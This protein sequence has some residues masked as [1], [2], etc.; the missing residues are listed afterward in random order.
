MPPT[1]LA[2]N[3]LAYYGDRAQA[4]LDRHDAPGASEAEIRAAVRDFLIETKLATA[5]SIQ[6]EQSPGDGSSGRVDLRTRDVIFEF[7]VR[8][9]NRI[10]PEAKHVQQLDD[11]LSAALVGGQQQRFGILTDGKYWILRWPGMGSVNTQPPN[12][13]TLA[14]AD[15]GLLLYEWLRDQ[16]QA[17]EAPDIPPTEDEIRNR[18]GTGPRFDLHL[19]ALRDLYTEHR[20]HP[21]IAV[22]RELWRRLL[23]A[24]LGQVVEEDPDL[25]DLFLR[26]TYLSVVVGLA[27][28]SAFGIEIEHWAAG[29]AERLLNGQLFAD[30]TGLS[31]VVES[32]FFTWL[33]EVGGEQWLRDLARRIAQFDWP[34]ADSDIARI[35]YESVI[36]AEERRRLGE[37]YTPDW[38]ARAIVDAVVTDP[39]EQR[40][41][42]PACG[43]GAFIFAAV[44][45]Y[46]AAA[47][48]AGWVPAQALDG[49]LNHVVGIDVHPV[50]VHL[51]RA[52]WTFAARDA[53]EAA[54]DANM[55][56]TVPVYLGDS[57]QL[58]TES[59]GMFAQQTVTI[60]VPDPPDADLEFNRELEFPRA[61]VEQADRFDN[62]M[63]SMASTIES[64][65]DPVWAL[66]DKGI[67]EGDDRKM[68]ERTAKLLQ[69]LHEE[70]RDHIWAYYT[71]NLVRPVALRANPVD[72]IVGNPPWLTY[73]RSQAVVREELERQSKDRY[74]IW[75][76]GRNAPNQE[77]AGLFFARCAE[78]YLKPG[79]AAAMVL[80]HSALQAGPFKK[81]RSGQ[82]GVVSVDLGIQLPWDLERIQ[83][84]D[85]FPLPACVAFLKRKDP[86]G[87][88]LPQHADRWRGPLGGPFE[89]ESVPL[90][91]TSGGFAS[92]YGD[93]A[94]RGADIFPR[95]LYLV[96]LE[97]STALVRAANTLIVSP[98]RTSQ[99][100]SPWR[101]L[102]AAALDGQAIEAEHVFDVHLG[103]TVAPYVLL[104]PLKAVLPLSMMTG[105]LIKKED[106][107]YGLDPLSLGGRMRRRWKLINELWDEN[108][109]ENSKLELLANLDYMHKLSS[110]QS[111]N[112][113][114]GWLV[115]YGKAGRPTAAVMNA[116]GCLVDKT[117]IWVPC[118]KIEEAHFLTAIINSKVLQE[119]LEPLM[120]KG[121]FGARDIEKHLWRLPIPEYDKDISLHREI[122]E[123]GKSAAGG[124]AQ[125][126]S[127]VRAEREA[128][129]K[130]FTVTIARRELRR[131]LS[132]SDEGRT[133]EGLVG[134]L[135]G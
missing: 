124:A 45:K 6:M 90:M 110:Q 13:F 116:Q 128:S 84:N 14:S 115:V 2:A 82:W 8:I 99:E 109:G 20:D 113:K 39:L 54:R 102:E 56:V 66:D 76:G 77:M 62:L 78:L 71:R 11:Y 7:K 51:A 69:R 134:R 70:G 91:D 28:Q 86:P 1:N 34:N 53:I 79:G 114:T 92:P 103:T 126:L 130:G 104:E 106:G 41:L 21:T 9:G 107:W 35:L 101:E 65:G 52:T 63:T 44:R 18:L 25:D 23:A 27:V 12:A 42:D 67:D 4:I 118:Q 98:R 94:R 30:E 46:L 111:S 72:V 100:K 96:T 33:L 88:P 75:A 43:S 135:L 83:P 15:H 37:Y 38:L 133:V 26:H 3:D 117:L 87:K 131:W 125:V 89:H 112:F 85:F 17:L 19:N 49:L 31:G 80:P 10:Q 59:S 40:V 123:A 73:N 93:K 105:D 24:A 32:D 127:E 74:V 58:R 55:T 48:E 97:E 5:D 60:P 95:V 108:K 129:G 64:G 81:W 122:A 119:T 121:Q 29:D 47:Q 22:K 16:A 50:A 57:L 120:P 36:P 68:L 132:E 61:L